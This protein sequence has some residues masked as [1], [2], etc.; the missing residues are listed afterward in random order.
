MRSHLFDTIDTLR[1]DLSR[2]QKKGLHFII[3]AVIIWIAI[4]FVQ[5]SSLS[6]IGKGIFTFFCSVPLMPLAYLISKVLRIDFNSKDNPLTSLG[7][8]FSI[9]QIP[10]L[11]IAMWILTVMPEHLLM[12]YA[13]IFGAHLLPYG[14]LYRSIGYY[15][16]AIVISITSLIIGIHYSPLILTIFMIGYELV[17]S[18]WLALEVRQLDSFQKK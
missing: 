2:Q 7:I 10:F 14:W 3:T 5:S 17:F 9:G 16:S 8:I 12:V 11:L 13:I 15:I 6:P 18:L 1:N 4:F